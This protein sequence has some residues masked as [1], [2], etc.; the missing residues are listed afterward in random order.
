MATPSFDS[1]MWYQILAKRTGKTLLGTAP[2]S[3]DKSKGA[4]IM[5]TA[6]ASGFSQRWQIY[7]INSTYWSLRTQEA[8]PDSWL[9]A[10]YKSA[11]TTEGNT[12][13]Y[14][15]RGDIADT[16]A[17]W[18][19]NPWGDGTWYL[20]NAAN[21]TN[22]RMN[23]KDGAVLAMSPNI[24]APQNGQRWH[25][26]EITAINNEKY[27]S[28][29]LL[30]VDIATSSVA[31]STP[32]SSPNPNLTSSSGLSRSA[33]AAVGA[34]IGGVALI[35][36]VVLGL[37]LWRRRKQRQARSSPPHES[38][39]HQPSETFHTPF[40]KYEMYHDGAARYEAPYSGILEAPGNEMPAELP[41]QAQRS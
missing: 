15:A 3:G 39:Q 12:R 41:G 1:N 30:G 11:E 22:Y 31:T 7:Q 36:F 17:F 2:F 38:Y 35:A 20:S 37:F 9:G 13:P 8:G 28:I 29:N 6:A 10:I 4:V 33:Q 21:G 25:F 14:M 23:D 24:T 34:S 27:S 19:I 26:K 18:A 16:S 5:G 40:A 32:T